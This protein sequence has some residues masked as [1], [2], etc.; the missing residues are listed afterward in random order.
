MYIPNS[1]ELIIDISS[2]RAFMNE[3]LN[4]LQLSF[5]SSFKTGRVVEDELR[6]SREVKRASDIMDTTLMISV[7]SS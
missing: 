3:L 4:F 6:V 1:V 5:I 7:M 2:F